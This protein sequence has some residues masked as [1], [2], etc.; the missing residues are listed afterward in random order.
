MCSTAVKASIAAGCGAWAE[1]NT[2]SAS[3]AIERDIQWQIQFIQAVIRIVLR[4]H[5]DSEIGGG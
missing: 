3:E 1:V 2:I 5:Y 4:T